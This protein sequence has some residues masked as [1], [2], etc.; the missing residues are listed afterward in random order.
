MTQNLYIYPGID[1]STW[2]SPYFS[3]SSGRVGVYYRFENGQKGQMIK[4]QLTPYIDEI[5]SELGSKVTWR[6]DDGP[7]G[8]F[9]I[10]LPLKN[11]YADQNRTKI[12]EFFNLWTNKFVNV[13]RPRLN[14][15]E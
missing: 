9:A 11:V 7:P 14:Q 2:I 10:L 1:K 3:A 8:A 6:W 13:L 15:L 4:E 12:V 5:R